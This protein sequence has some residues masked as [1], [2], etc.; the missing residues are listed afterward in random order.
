MKIHGAALLEFLAEGNALW[1][2]CSWCEEGFDD[3][4]VSPIGIYDTEDLGY[5]EAQAYDAQV[6]EEITLVLFGKKMTTFNGSLD[7][8]PVLRAWLRQRNTTTLVI[9]VPNARLTEVTA[10]LK[11]SKCSV[12]RN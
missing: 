3:E 5:L 6:H 9:E 1:E 12:L 11:A 10:Y 4:S 7:I 8:E 2:T